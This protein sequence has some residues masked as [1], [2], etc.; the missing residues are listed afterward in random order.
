[1][2]ELHHLQAAISSTLVICRATST[3]PSS[4][5]CDMLLHPIC[6]QAALSLLASCR[7]T[8]EGNSRPRSTWNMSGGYH[9][10]LT[11]VMREQVAVVMY[12]KWDPAKR[13]VTACVLRGSIAASCR[14]SDSSAGQQAAEVCSRCPHQDAQ[15]ARKQAAPAL[16]E[17]KGGLSIP[18]M[19]HKPCTEWPSVRLGEPQVP[20]DLG[21]ASRMEQGGPIQQLPRPAQGGTRLALASSGF[22][23]MR[24]F[25]TYSMAFTSWLVVRSTCSNRQP[26]ASLV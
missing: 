17:V 18:P 20:L 1:M 9:S 19:P 7:L 12:T 4:R 8:C 21:L 14:S 22:P 13:L 24:S 11:P 3:W 26:S 16:V 25:S 23:L 6:R 5:A 10:R 2:G 15:A